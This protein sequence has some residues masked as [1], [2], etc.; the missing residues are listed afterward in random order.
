MLATLAVAAL[1][2]ACSD[3]G[4]GEQ[5]STGNLGP[6][7]PV[8]PGT[9]GGSALVSVTV[10]GAVPTSGNGLVTGASPGAS[11]PVGGTLRQVVVEGT[12]GS[13]QH[14]FTVSY[15]AASGVVLSVLHAWGTTSATA[16]AATQC[17]RTVSAVGQVACGAAV[18][19]DLAANRIVFT[20]TV[21]RNGT[22]SSIL[23]GQVPY[24]VL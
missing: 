17:V 16:D 22:F 19:V 11:T 8:G 6:V 14:R 13:V 4:A 5:G 15:D 7:S 24:T 20:G 1:L 9:G 21:L 12:G 3:G 10:T 2:A 18:A 23:S